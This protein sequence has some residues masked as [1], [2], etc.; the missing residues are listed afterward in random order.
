MSLK[1]WLRRRAELYL[2]RY[3]EGP[4]PP[5]R[6]GDVVLLF[7]EQVPDATRREWIAFAIR[8]GDEGYRQGYV[9]GR[10]HAD[11]DPQPEVDPDAI[12]RELAPRWEESPAVRLEGDLDVPVSAEP[13]GDGRLPERVIERIV[14]EPRDED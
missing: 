7:A 10:E 3:R 5:P 1:S 6:L 14:R 13:M 12:M 4:E 9:R 2:G 8:H 11:R